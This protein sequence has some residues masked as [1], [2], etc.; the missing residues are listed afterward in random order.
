LEQGS[1]FLIGTEV[2]KAQ[3]QLTLQ[4]IYKEIHILQRELVPQEELDTV[5]SYIAG[6]FASEVDTPFAL[7][8]KFKTIYFNNLDYS[9]YAKFFQT[10]KE[11][12]GET[13]LKTCRQYLNT[14]QLSQVIIG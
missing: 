7:A 1:L 8:D 2:K 13:V 11:I 5:T 9:Y 6:S 10:L 12:N 14:D 3:R 4:E